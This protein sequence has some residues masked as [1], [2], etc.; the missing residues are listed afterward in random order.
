[1]TSTFLH[2]TYKE[3]FRAFV[4]FV[5]TPLQDTPSTEVIFLYQMFKNYNH[6]TSFLSSI[7]DWLC[8]L[9]SPSLFLGYVVCHS[10]APQSNI[11]HLTKSF[12][13]YHTQMV[14]ENWKCKTRLSIGVFSPMTNRYKRQ[15]WLCRHGTYSC[16]P[17]AVLGLHTP[18]NNKRYQLGSILHWI[19]RITWLN[20]MHFWCIC[21][22]NSMRSLFH[23]TRCNLHTCIRTM[24]PEFVIEL[25]SSS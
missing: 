7:W 10:V 8:E 25:L 11:S 13:L 14:S 17:I 22:F 1:M 19:E 24:Q 3:Y 12:R 6:Q 4:Y 5:Y 21:K 2:V 20:N 16:V 23:R 9:Y 15:L 18:I